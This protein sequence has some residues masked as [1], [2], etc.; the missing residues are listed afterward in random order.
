MLKVNKKIGLTNI[1]FNPARY[2]TVFNQY[3]KGIYREIIAMMK[4][5]IADSHVAGCLLGRDA[6]YQKEY[7]L[8][9]YSEAKPDIERSKW[10]RSIL[11]NI[12]TRSLF[13]AIHEARKYKFSVIDFDWQIKDNKQ[14]PLSFKKFD[15]KYF[16]YDPNDNYQTLKIDF[17]NLLKDISPDVLVCESDEMPIMLPVL[18][19]Y[20]LKEFGLESWASFLETFGE[21]FIF[22]KYP[23]GCDPKIKEE[24]EAGIETMASSSRGTMPIGT[25]IEVVETSR[26]TGDHE[27]FKDTA[28]KGISIGL[29]G[30][31]N[32]V[33]SGKGLQV[34]ENLSSYKVKREVAVDDLFFIEPFM[35]RLINQIIDRNFGDGKYTRFQT[36]KSEPLDLNK[37]SKM[38]DMAYSH[39]VKL[40]P[41]EYRK[42]GL[43]IYDDQ[44]PIQKSA[45]PFDG[46]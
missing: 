30:H 23:S 46:I 10:I 5:T 1:L 16:R 39:G 17:G 34:G 11:D 37:H 40:H 43:Y 15:Q 9:P 6:G 33:T 27:K 24:L 12:N 14:I 32:A 26:T 36:D 4:R 3:Q 28:D 13:K 25:E 38:L 35:Q 29:L 45:N 41:D 21:P 18:R 20:I 19:D 8:I 7:N 44:E 2:K 42:L 22:G 31:E